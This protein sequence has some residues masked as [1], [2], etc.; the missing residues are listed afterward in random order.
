MVLAVVLKSKPG[1][2]SLIYFLNDLVSII[3][4]F[5]MILESIILSLS[6]SIDLICCSNENNIL[7]D[8]LSGSLLINSLSLISITSSSLPFNKE[9][10]TILF[11]FGNLFSN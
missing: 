2:I 11:D 5:L 1:V 10:V 8:I 7:L 9:K 4:N 6:P 3:G